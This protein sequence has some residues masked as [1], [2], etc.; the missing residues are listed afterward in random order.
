MAN[1]QANFLA[2]FHGLSWLPVLGDLATPL[3]SNSAGHVV[4]SVTQMETPNKVKR[5]TGRSTLCQ[6]RSGRLFCYVL[7]PTRAGGH[8]AIVIHR[9]IR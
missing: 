8:N 2:S 6:H 5:I 1:F 7:L 4:L 3:A 9:G